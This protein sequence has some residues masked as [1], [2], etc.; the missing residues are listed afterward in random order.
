MPKL[1]AA[2]EEAARSAVRVDRSKISLAVGLR[3]SLGV[4]LCLVVGRASGHTVA[5]VTTTIGALS[6]GMASH[7]G[8]YRS[9]AG[10]VLMAGAAMGFCATVGALVGHLVGPDIVATAVIGF[11][12]ALLVCLGPSGTV[13]GIQAVVGLVVFSQFDFP[14]SVALR[15]GGLV[16][17]GGA[18]QALLIVVIWPLRRFSSER[19]TLSDAFSALAGYCRAAVDPETTVIE[20]GALDGLDAVW[21][22]AQPFGG[23]E[24]AAYRALAAQ[25]DRLRLEIVAIARART[26]LAGAGAGSGSGSASGSGSGGG[27]AGRAIDNVLAA[28]RGVLDEVADAIRDARRPAGWEEF[29]GRYRA[30]RDDLTRAAEAEPGTWWAGAA[31]D[32]ERRVD[33]LS[34]QLRAVIRTAAVPAGAQPQELDLEMAGHPPGPTGARSR[35]AWVQERWGT[36]RSN[37]TLSSQACRH[38]L[39]MAVT[40]SVAV[41]VSH[42]FPYQHHY[43]L[44]MTAL[45]VL[46]PDFTSTVSRGVSRVVGTLFGAGLVTL[47]LAELRPSPD[48]LIVLVIALC[49]PAATLVLANYAVYSVCIASLVVTLLAFTGNPELG[50]AGDRSIYTVAGAAVAFLAYFAWPTW[51]GTSL[52]DTLADLAATEG[53]YAGG[54]LRAWTDAAGADRAALQRTRLEARLARS[55]AEAAVTRWLNEPAG[56]A[57][58]ARDTVV[59][60]MAAIRSCVQALLTLHAELPADGPGHPAAAHLAD[61]VE[62]AFASLAATVKGTASPTP[63]PPLRGEQLALAEVLQADGQAGAAVV[64]AGE[65]DLLVDSI[66]AMGHLLGLL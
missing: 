8:T 11:A 16:L 54:V 66:D 13:V 45:L 43:W 61:L 15:D 30:A 51:E 1:A 26:R 39:R 27:A 20:P 21:R 57:A 31:T 59:G 53:R 52:R 40:L 2:V 44:P 56:G 12:A 34:G 58:V 14:W 64:L 60:Y 33:A 3:A 38:A 50:T 35:P 62:Q 28:T 29:R 63:F 65:T 24:I 48:W 17:L 42:A 5:G 18:V 37:L 55:N 49:I 25:A 22:D 4:G 46:R 7:Q 36:V 32:A 6:A 23:D 9:R 41:A 47:A 10:V 19:R